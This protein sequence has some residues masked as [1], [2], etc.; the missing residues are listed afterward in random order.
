MTMPRELPMRRI[1]TDN[2]FMVNV[3]FAAL[4]ARPSNDRFGPASAD[5]ARRSASRVEVD[6]SLSAANG[7]F[8]ATPRSIRA[9][10]L[11]RWGHWDWDP[12]Y[13]PYIGKVDVGTLR[14]DSFAR[15]CEIIFRRAC[16]FLFHHRKSVTILHAPWRAHEVQLLRFG[17]L[18]LPMFGLRAAR[19]SDDC[20]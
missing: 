20:L 5:R 18:A 15:P 1:P 3:R 4:P 16:I 2:A 12:F 14:K 9:Y 6:P 11:T 19:I 13:E 10:H 7:G 17:L 8:Q